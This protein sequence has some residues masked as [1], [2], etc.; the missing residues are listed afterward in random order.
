MKT[1]II[2]LTT[3]ALAATASPVHAGTGFPLVDGT[4]CWGMNDPVVHYSPVVQRALVFTN[5]CS[6]LTMTTAPECQEGQMAVT[7]YSPLLHYPNA[8]A[9]ELAIIGL[10]QAVQ[11]GNC[12]LFGPRA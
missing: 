3:L 6:D 1:K 12:P 11:T 2:S 9:E 4:T 8:G 7:K 5:L 10:D